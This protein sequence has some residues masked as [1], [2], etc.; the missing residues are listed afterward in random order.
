MTWAV[1]TQGTFSRG[2][3]LDATAVRYVSIAKAKR[4][5]GYEPRVELHEALKISCEVSMYPFDSRTL[6]IRA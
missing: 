1:G 4:I 2:A 6:L 5:L 3:V